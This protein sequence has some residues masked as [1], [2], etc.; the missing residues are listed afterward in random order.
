D[1]RGLRVDQGFH[2]GVVSNGPSFAPSHAEGRDL[3]MAQRQLADLLKIFEILRVGERIA[4]F[5]EI[6]SQLVQPASDEQL[7][8]QR[9]IDALSL[10]A[11]AKR[12]VVDL[13]ASH[14]WSC[15]KKALKL[16]APGLRSQIETLPEPRSY[17]PPSTT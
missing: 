7:V 12:R 8:L 5:D 4:D 3:G 9:K 14:T 6:H 15:N 10:A 1:D 2:A 11:V 17:F 13:N 16:I